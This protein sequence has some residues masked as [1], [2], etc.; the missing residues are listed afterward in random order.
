MSS[1]TRR[2][3]LRTLGL[4]G[5]W[6]WLPAGARAAAPAAREI[7]IGMSAALSGPSAQLGR[8]MRLGVNAYLKKV[9]DAGGVFGR[10]LR[11]VVL[12]DSYQAEPVGHNMQRLI[13]EAGV[14]AV[15][16]SVGTAG[17]GVAAPIANARHVLLFGAFSGADLLRRTPPDRYVINVRASYAEE[18]AVMVRGLLRKGI[19][20]QQIAFFT[21][22][23]AY[24]DS[25][26]AGAVRAI[27][28]LGYAD[29][30]TLAHGRYPRGTLDVEDGLLEVVQAKARPRAVIMVGA[31]GACAKFIKL[32]RQLLTDT[33][34]LNVSFVGSEALTAALGTD[35]NGVIVTQVVPHYDSNLPGTAEYRAALERYA[36]G[37]PRDFVSLEGFLVA[38]AFVEGLRR[39]GHEPTRDAVVDAIERAGTIDIGIGVPL[40][41]SAKEHQGSHHVWLTEIRDGK[42]VSIDW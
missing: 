5:A 34:Y 28:A 9:N 32:A 8:G 14:L 27:E 35:G 18:T 10:R 41:F 36:P 26:Y 7:V 2:S 33:L 1:I 16:G 25:G 15:V 29:A 31:Y 17:A 22:D 11:L 4:S 40:H 21:Q 37:T 39:A 20:P 38:K 13:D 23:D 3:L 24:G 42:L 19:K 30:K 6:L 12:D